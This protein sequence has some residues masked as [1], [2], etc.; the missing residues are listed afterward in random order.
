MPLHVF[1]PE[2]TCQKWFRHTSTSEDLHPALMD[3]LN[4]LGG[5]GAAT[6]GAALDAAASSI[7]AA[8]NTAGAAVRSAKVDVQRL[9]PP[10][11]S[12][13]AV[14][15]IVEATDGVLPNRASVTDRSFVGLYP[16][17]SA[18]DMKAL[19]WELVCQSRWED[20]PAGGRRIE[21][22]VPAPGFNGDWTA[23][24]WAAAAYEARYMTHTETTLRAVTEQMSPH[25]FDCAGR[26]RS[27]ELRPTHPIVQISVPQRLYASGVT[28]PSVV[29]A[30]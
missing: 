20:T 9:D 27:F 24:K 15:C 17:G 5:V 18:D 30:K 16:V 14:S 7:D 19:T 6:L 2:C 23:F 26:S 10:Y 28:I 29:E 3:F 22:V 8:A 13:M 1:N 25:K 11:T 12:G 21:I 4:T